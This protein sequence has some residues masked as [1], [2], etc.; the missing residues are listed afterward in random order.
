M[1]SEF[2]PPA[3]ILMGPGPSN[4]D[5]RVLLAM[6]KPLL[7]HLDPDFIRIMRRIQDELRFVF[8]TKNFYTLPISGTGT[9]GME[10]AFA[11]IVEPGER[12]LIC[13]NGVFGERMVEIAGRCGA[14]VRVFPQTWGLP[15]DPQAVEKEIQAFRPKV[16]AIVHAETSTG[17]LQPIE[18]LAAVLKKYPETLFLVDTV[19][20]LGGIPVKVDEW[21]IDV[22]Y[23]G[24]QKCLSC[25]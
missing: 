11:N 12:V 7:G 22:C 5:P 9:L 16:V 2:N 8:G 17:V 14:D 1:S 4:A 13:V 18:E 6:A 15:F 10:A 23:S 21:G 3:R 20:S 24:T 19:T 25:P